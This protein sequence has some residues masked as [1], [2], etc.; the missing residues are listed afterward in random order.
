MDVK[1]KKSVKSTRPPITSYAKSKKTD[2]ITKGHLPPT[3]IDKSANDL[4]LD[5][6]NL[7]YTDLDN[8]DKEFISDISWLDYDSAS[9][10]SILEDIVASINI[11]RE[12][13]YQIINSSDS[14]T[15]SDI[16]DIL[17]KLPSML[18]LDLNHAINAEEEFHRIKGS[19]SVVPCKV[20]GGNEFYMDPDRQTSAGDEASRSMRSCAS[21]KPRH[22]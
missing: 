9:F 17:F 18:Q 3:S 19:L 8:A 15:D 1:S 10:E 11:D 2:T 12:L 20:C 16:N 5:V 22:N 13:T 21:C 6:L 7:L 4:I 14:H